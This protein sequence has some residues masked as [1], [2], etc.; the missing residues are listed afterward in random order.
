MKIKIGLMTILMALLMAGVAAA[1][2]TVPTKFTSVYTSLS[3]GCK[4]LRGRDGQDDAFVC[5]GAGNYQV[6]VYYSA[7]SSHILAELKGTDDSVM[8][9]T[10]SVGF[11]ESKTTLEWRLANG[12]PFA[13]IMRQPIYSENVAEG[14]Y[15]GKVIGQQLVIN[16][17]VGFEEKITG[18]VD[19]KTPNANVKARE[20]ADNAYKAQAK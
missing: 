15:F 17:L 8:L 7:A 4:T 9:A 5:R 10:L 16:G 1:Q 18:E 6:R 3:K 11:D 14:E 2:K 13:V 20:L 19:A 12:K